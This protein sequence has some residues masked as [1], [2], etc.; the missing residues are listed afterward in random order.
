MPCR[1]LIHNR[2]RYVGYAQMINQA[3]DGNLVSKHTVAVTIGEVKKILGRVR[4]VDHATGP[5][6]ATV[7]MCP[8]PT[9]W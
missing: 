9:T 7:W 8:I 4:P 6:W 5:S 1:A 3:W 2:G